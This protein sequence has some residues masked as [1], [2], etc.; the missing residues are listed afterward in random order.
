MRAPTDDVPRAAI[1]DA[2]HH[3]R[4]DDRSERRAP[5]VEVRGIT[6]RYPAS[7]RAVLAEFSAT[8]RPGALTVVVGETGAGK[9]TLGDVLL[10]LLPPE[11]G[12]VLVDGVPLSTLPRDAWRARVG[13]LAQEPM[14]FHGTI[15]ENLRFARPSATDAQL[16]AALTAAACD[17]VGRLP[18]RLD[19]E[20]GDRGVL[21]SGGERQRLALARALLREPDLLVLDEAT[22]ALDA[23]TEARI[24]Q[25]VRALRGRCTVVFCT[26]RAA[27]RAMADQVIEL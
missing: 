26:H 5:A 2:P 16:D 4:G 9:T 7:E 17:F 18:H 13:Y 24:L 22:S 10:G 1:A 3:T 25:T 19:S 12:A 11:S 20:V 6:V 23:E 8:C 15:R 27:V 14:L 21:L